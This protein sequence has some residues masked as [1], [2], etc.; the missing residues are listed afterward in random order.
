MSSVKR[1]LLYGENKSAYTTVAIVLLT[2]DFFCLGL[3]AMGRTLANLY[4]RKRWY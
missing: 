3:I 1:A 2:P 4:N